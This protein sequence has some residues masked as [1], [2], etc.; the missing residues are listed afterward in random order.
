MTWHA[1]PREAVECHS[2]KDDFVF[3]N[4]LSG[5]THL[6]GPLPARMIFLLQESSLDSLSLVKSLAL[7]SQGTDDAEHLLH[8]EEIL[9]ELHSLTL[10]ER[11]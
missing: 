10:I 7:N 9:T 3:Y 8:V 5:A 6:L 1:L 4:A 2:W 11:S